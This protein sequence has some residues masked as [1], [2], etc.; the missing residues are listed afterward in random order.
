MR[1]RQG[2][3][4]NGGRRAERS[5]ASGETD[6]RG[7]R[8]KARRY[9]E[10]RWGHCRCSRRKKRSAK[11][12]ENLDEMNRGVEGGRGGGVEL[13]WRKEEFRDVGEKA[14]ERV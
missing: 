11:Q 12:R 4:C 14:A 1:P 9:I 8:K 2:R 5:R 6:S 10:K 7:P 3:R 13:R